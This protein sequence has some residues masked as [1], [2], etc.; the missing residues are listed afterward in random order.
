MI[1][2]DNNQYSLKVT[3]S[4][5][6]I[7]RVKYADDAKYWSEMVGRHGHLS[8]LAIEPLE[9]TAVQQGRLDNLPSGVQSASLYVEYGTDEPDSPHYDATAYQR[10]QEASVRPAIEYQRKLQE[11]KGVTINGVRYSGDASNRQALSEALQAAD[12]MG[13]THFDSWLDSDK[14]THNNLPVADVYAALLAIGRRR[15]ALIAIESQHVAATANGDAAAVDW[16]LADE[17]IYTELAEQGSGIVESGSGSGV[18]EF[19]NG[20]GVIGN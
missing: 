10:A 16:S 7:E 1:K 6:G 20:S 3:F 5:N 9:L 19:E 4:D 14:N 13:I 2:S 15:S 8:N 11:S 12:A 18:I 17:G